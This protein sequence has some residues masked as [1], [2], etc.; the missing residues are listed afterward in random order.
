MNAQI[1][2]IALLVIPVLLLLFLRVNASIVF[3]SLCLGAVLVQFVGPD[4][5][6]ISS[7]FAARGSGAPSSQSMVNLVLQLLPVV[8]TTL[9]MI[10]SVYGKARNMFNLFPAIGV[11]ALLTLL[12]VPLLNY[13]L[14]SQITHSA[15]WNELE[16]AQTLII[17]ATTLLTLLS[18]WMQRPKRHFDEHH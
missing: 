3:M 7:S 10:H 9:F 6:T 1:I 18:L 16:N 12:T 8:L 5:A 14:T 2:L 4:A 15:L 17:S 11:S 13:G